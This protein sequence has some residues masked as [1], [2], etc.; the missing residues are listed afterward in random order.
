MMKLDEDIAL[1]NITA[2]ASS[3]DIIT[4]TLM[5]TKGS[6]QTRKIHPK[7]HLNTTDRGLIP[8]GCGPSHEGPVD[9]T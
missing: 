3:K 8:R 9:L 7:S 5:P 2:L 1:N 6:K 4:P